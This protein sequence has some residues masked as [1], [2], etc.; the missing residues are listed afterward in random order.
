MELQ[1]SDNI[2]D[3]HL[4]TMLDVVLESS[5]KQLEI[6]RTQLKKD[7]QE[8][9]KRERE[10][11]FRECAK[12]ECLGSLQVKLD[13]Y[14]EANNKLN[15]GQKAK[16]IG[17]SNNSEK[18][19]D[20]LRAIGQYRPNNHWQAHHIVCS[21]HGSHAAARFKLFAYLGLNDPFNG[22]WLP[23]KHKHATSTPFPNAV[24]HAYLH[25][26]Q[27]AD[28]VRREVRPANSKQDLINRL[29]DIR[30][31]LHN[32]QSLPDVLTE[33]GKQDLRTVS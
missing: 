14:R 24:G 10:F 12:L 1:I 2:R 33:N 26:N 32:A 16:E 7:P 17:S 5:Q 4:K 29:R 25:T 11:M 8:L 20:H 28:W 9:A 21:R 27:Y 22:C 13:N 18:L 31:R 19:G 30:L 3:V 23:S 15:A 6:L